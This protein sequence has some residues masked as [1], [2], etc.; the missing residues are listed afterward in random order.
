MVNKEL[1]RIV[2]P[3]VGS[4]G[5]EYVG[6][7]YL[8]QGKHS[9]LRVYIDNPDGGVT[10]NDCETVSRQLSAVLDVEEPIRGAYNLEVSSPGLDRPLFT[11]AQFNQF[12][13]QEGVVRVRTPVNGR[14][15][16]TG[17]LKGVKDGELT[18]DVDGEQFVL[19]L[20]VIEKANLVPVVKF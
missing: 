10:V 3:V 2:E 8:S 14:R 17:T 4:F 5:L 15:K 9:V 13:G 19:P 11:E 1:E 20:D 6:L 12:T 18:I 7:E 16:F